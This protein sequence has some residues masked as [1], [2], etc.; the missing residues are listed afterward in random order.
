MRADVRIYRLFL[1]RKLFHRLLLVVICGL[2]QAGY[3]PLK[4]QIDPDSQYKVA[5]E[6]GVKLMETGDYRAADLKFKQVLRNMEVLPADITFYFGKNSYFLDEY[7]Q[8]IN[9]LNK[10]MELK[11]TQGRFFD[12]CVNY[13]KKAELS[14]KLET[15]KNTR[16][17]QAEFSK[18]NEFDCRGKTHFQC[19]L[20]KGE[21]VLIKPGKMNNTVYQTC[22]FC[23]GA[24]LLTCEKYKKFVRGELRIENQ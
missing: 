10:Y 15:E 1:S 21:G 16:Q 22:P 24:G 17:I 11:G 9:W 8:S 3:T 4:A 6:E 7:K 23:D 5:M 20:C 2:L 18:T 12:E 14:Y 19:P 13:L